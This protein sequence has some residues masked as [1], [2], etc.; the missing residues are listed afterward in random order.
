MQISIGILVKETK[1]MRKNLEGQ[2]VDDLAKRMDMAPVT[3]IS[4]G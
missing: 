2:M 3:K 4:K 1:H